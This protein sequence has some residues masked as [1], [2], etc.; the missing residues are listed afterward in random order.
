MAASV[1]TA[2]H[3]FAASGLITNATHSKALDDT[4]LVTELPTLET[5]A[6]I[7]D[8]WSMCNYFELFDVFHRA[9]YSSSVVRQALEWRQPQ[10]NRTKGRQLIQWVLD[11]Y[12][13]FNEDGAPVSPSMIHSHW[14]GFLASQAMALLRA[15]ELAEENEIE[16]DITGLTATSLRAAI[17]RVLRGTNAAE[18]FAKCDDIDD[19][20]FAWSGPSYIVKRSDRSEPYDST[21]QGLT[22]FDVEFELGMS[23]HSGTRERPIIIDSDGEGSLPP[24]P[25]IQEACISFAIGL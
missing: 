13:F 6:Q 25:F 10:G 7:V 8:L 20:T 9:T 1:A 24:P 18:M 23:E 12:N 21:I 15:K 4:R 14:T 17:V 3:T 19:C 22:P 16:G 5:F 2:F 11:N